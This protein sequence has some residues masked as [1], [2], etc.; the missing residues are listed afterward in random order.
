MLKKV[1]ILL[2]I[3]FIG[4]AAV[5]YSIELSFSPYNN[6]PKDG[7]VDGRLYTWGHLVVKNR[8]GFRGRNFETPKPKGVYRVAVF[9]DSLT[10]GVGLAVNERYTNIAEQLLNE[11]FDDRQF[12]V[13]NFGICGWSTVKERDHLTADK[14]RFSRN[15]SIKG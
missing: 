5:L 9:G 8:Y 11:A 15:V 4:I 14:H 2:F 13:L 1:L 3:N 7:V 10:Y 6:L 12:E